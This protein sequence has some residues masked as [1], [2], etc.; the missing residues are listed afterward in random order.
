V[1]AIL[2]NKPFVWQAN[3]DNSD[4]LRPLFGVNTELP[5]L[6]YGLN[7]YSKINNVVLLTASNP[8]PDQYRF[9]KNQGMNVDAVRHAIHFHNAYQTVMRTS[10]RVPS[11]TEPKIVIV[12]DL[13]LAE[14]LSSY[15]LVPR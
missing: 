6:A 1:L 8:T 3:K 13:P 14:H 2:S 7:D 10:I 9:P 15:F 5:H 4:A 12:P 11:N